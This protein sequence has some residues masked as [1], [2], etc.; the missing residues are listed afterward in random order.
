MRNLF[1]LGLLF[2]GQGSRPYDTKLLYGKWLCTET[3]S[4]MLKAEVTFNKDGTCEQVVYGRHDTLQMPGRFEFKN[5]TIYYHVDNSDGNILKYA[6]PILDQKKM[7]WVV[8]M[9]NGKMGLRSN[10][11]RK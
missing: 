11:K 10:F 6:I 3:S 7:Q 4:G 2:L 1:F 9:N 5:D 8:I